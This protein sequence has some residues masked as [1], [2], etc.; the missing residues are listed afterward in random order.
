MDA[1]THDLGLSLAQECRRAALVKLPR[2]YDEV[3]LLFRDK[4]SLDKFT[5]D[6]KGRGLWFNESF[7]SQQN[8]ATDEWEF[9]TE[10]QFSLPYMNASWRIE[11][12]RVEC[13]HAPLHQRHI[14]GHGAPSVVHVSWKA[15]TREEYLLEKVALF[16][17]GMTFHAEYENSYGIF[18]YWSF[19][20]DNVFMYYKPRVNVRDS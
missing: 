2:L 6:M 15:P 1:F 20:K 5:K 10:F 14:E 7:E 9:D 16:E 8:T 3:S 4:K 12:M 19:E 18:S 17:E 13:G 11:A